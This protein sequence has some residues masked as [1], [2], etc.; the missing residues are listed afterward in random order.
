MDKRCDICVYSGCT[1]NLI[2]EQ[3]VSEDYYLLVKSEC[4][5][6]EIRSALGKLFPSNLKYRL[7]FAVAEEVVYLFQIMF[8]LRPKEDCLA[9]LSGCNLFSKLDVRL[10]YNEIELD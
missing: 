4:E 3:F 9:N 2:S 10:A 7:N 8:I 5:P 1:L 6:V